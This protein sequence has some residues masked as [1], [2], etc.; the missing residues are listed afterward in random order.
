MSTMINGERVITA[1]EL[2]EIIEVSMDAITICVPSS[3][4][5]RRSGDWEE[6]TIVFIDPNILLRELKNA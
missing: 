1:K 4:Y 2:A 3:D 5:Y 6:R